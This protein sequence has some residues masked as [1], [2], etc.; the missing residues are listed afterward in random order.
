M[1]ERVNEVCLVCLTGPTLCLPVCI[2]DRWD[3]GQVWFERMGPCAASP[4]EWTLA[5]AL[6]RAQKQQQEQP[7]Q[8]MEVLHVCCA[9]C[10]VRSQNTPH[11]CMHGLTSLVLLHYTFCSPCHVRNYCVA[12]VWCSICSPPHISPPLPLLPQLLPR[13]QFPPL[14][15]LLL[16]FLL[17]IRSL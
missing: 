3:C 8:V 16:H 4:P 17:M 2:C 13:L 1:E 15:P 6:E 14:L 5:T 12:W 9:C 7:E 10:L 11:T